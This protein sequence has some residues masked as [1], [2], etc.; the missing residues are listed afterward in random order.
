MET[1]EITTIERNKLIAEF[2]EFTVFE[3]NGHFEVHAHNQSVTFYKRQNN[4]GAQGCWF[5]YSEM[6]FNSS[7]DWIMPVV[8][9]IESMDFVLNIRKGHVS[10]LNNSGKTPFYTGGDIVEVSKFAA[11]YKTVIEFI[12]WYNSQNKL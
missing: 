2:M 12:K 1:T 10:I 8:E 5:S 6:K 3:N 4:G 7:W 11:I 9:K